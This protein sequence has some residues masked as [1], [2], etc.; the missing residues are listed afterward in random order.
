[1][2]RFFDP[3]THPQGLF[4]SANAHEL[5]RDVERG[6]A[7]DRVVGAKDGVRHGRVEHRGDKPALD[8]IAEWQ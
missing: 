4:P 5:G 7:A 6:N 1:M 8:N 3:A 2:G